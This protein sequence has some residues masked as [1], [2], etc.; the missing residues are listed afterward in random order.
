MPDVARAAK[1]LSGDPNYEQIVRHIREVLADCTETLVQA[2]DPID[3]HRAQG[4][5]I[6][7]RGLLDQIAP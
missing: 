3:T 2:R 6:E 7:L 1:N 5:V 4:A